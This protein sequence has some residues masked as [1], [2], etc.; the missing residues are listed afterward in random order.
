M[1]KFNMLNGAYIA[2][3]P[4]EGKLFKEALSYKDEIM[5]ERRV[6]KTRKIKEKKVITRYAWAFKSTKHYLFY[7]GHLGR[8]ISYLKEK[9]IPYEFENLTKSAV[10]IDGKLN[11]ITLRKD[12]Q[13]LLDLA[14]KNRRGV[15]KAGTGTGKSVIISALMA[16][17]SE[18]SILV[19]THLS[20]LVAQLKKNFE[21]YL[22][23]P[24]TR[25]TTGNPTSKTRLTITTIQTLARIPIDDYAEKYNIVIVDECFAKNT[26]IRMDK[27]NKQIQNICVGEKVKTRKGNKTVKRTFINEIPLNRLCKVSLSNGKHIFCSVDHIYKT[28]TGEFPAKNLT[29]KTLLSINE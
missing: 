14:I 3:T 9:N 25:L 2:V 1:I 10:T 13:K 17:Y 7:R 6:S 19:I 26:K 20:D 29:G 28:T 24:V 5:V 27:K 23:E 15:I 18:S 8:V 22:E 16:C 21:N 4:Q 12:Q 11:G